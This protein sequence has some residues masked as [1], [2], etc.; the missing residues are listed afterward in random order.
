MS[1]IDTR[2]VCVLPG[3]AQGGEQSLEFQE[4]RILAGTHHIS[5]DSPCVMINRMPEP[6]LSRFGPNETPHFIELGG[7]TW[8]NADGARTRGRRHHGVDV[9][10][11]GDFFLIWRSQ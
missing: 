2:F 6:T 9:S 5:K 10:K 8:L 3:D 4:H 1:L 7:A 11:R